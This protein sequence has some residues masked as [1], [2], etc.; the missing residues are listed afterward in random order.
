ML[1]LKRSHR[2]RPGKIWAV[3]E[4]WAVQGGRSTGRI[5]RSSVASHAACDSG[6][7]GGARLGL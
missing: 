1:N 3:A 6:V 5:A 7:R 4:Y 2:R